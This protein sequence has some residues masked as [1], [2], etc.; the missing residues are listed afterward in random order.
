MSWVPFKKVGTSYKDSLR[1]MTLAYT[2]E[3]P[4]GKRREKDLVEEIVIY[5]V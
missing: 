1:W 2:I 4:K 3:G 5:S